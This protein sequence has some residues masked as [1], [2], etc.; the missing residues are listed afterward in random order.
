MGLK[1]KVIIYIYIYL[2]HV[3]FSDCKRLEELKKY[4]DSEEYTP[5]QQIN[6]IYREEKECNLKDI[7]LKWTEIT[8]RNKEALN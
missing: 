4:L 8:F 3:I 2:I 6:R 1:F 5:I 7:V